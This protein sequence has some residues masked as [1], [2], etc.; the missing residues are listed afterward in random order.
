MLAFGWVGC[1]C[2]GISFEKNSYAFQ[3]SVNHAEAVHVHQPVRNAD[4]L[5]GMSVGFCGGGDRGAAHKLDA[6]R[7]FVLPDK[8]NDVPVFHP[9]RN[10]REPVFTYCHPKQR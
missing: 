2:G 3:V 7:V 10:H 1:K 9:F 6:V 5:N 8:L 4:Q